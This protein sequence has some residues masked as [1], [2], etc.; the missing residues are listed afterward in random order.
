[1]PA[2]NSFQRD[3]FSRIRMTDDG[4][5][6]DDGYGRWIRRHGMLDL[7]DFLF[8]TDLLVLASPC[9][10]ETRTNNMAACLSA[11]KDSL[12]DPTLFWFG[13]EYLTRCP[14]GS[15]SDVSCA[16]FKPSA[17]NIA[18]RIFSNTASAQSVDRFMEMH[19][20]SGGSKSIFISTI[21]RCLPYIFG[22]F[23]HT[24]GK[25]TFRWCTFYV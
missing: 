12:L 6:T 10:K 3:C 9:S 19:F 20:R 17:T 16:N 2:H 22:I 1:M 4:Q 23:S 5:R 7:H 21:T 24:F 25:R 11:I 8:V 18:S 15:I 13:N 14:G